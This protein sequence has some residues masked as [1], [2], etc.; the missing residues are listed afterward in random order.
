MQAILTITEE[1]NGNYKL[2]MD[3]PKGCNVQKLQVAL[4]EQ[5]DYLGKLADDLKILQ[6]VTSTRLQTAFE[7]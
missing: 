3:I 4:T 7:V 5:A 1:P 2:Y 6:G